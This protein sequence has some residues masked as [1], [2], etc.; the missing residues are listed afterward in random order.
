MLK[1][2]LVWATFILVA[3]SASMTLA[4]GNQDTGDVELYELRK[5]F[6]ETSLDGNRQ[7]VRYWQYGWSSFYG[8]SAAA[9]TALWIDAD[10]ND[11]RVNYA[12]GALKSAAGLTEMLL[13]PHPGR[14]G[15]TP[16]Q[17]MPQKTPAQRRQRLDSGESTLRDSAKRAESRYS[18]K[19]HIKVVGVNLVAGA[20]IAGFG[21]SGDA[22]TSTAIGIA[23][24]EA[25]IWTQPTRPEDDWRKYQQEFP[26]TGQVAEPAWQ[27]V[28]IFGGIALVGKF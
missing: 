26:L 9:Q 10:N 27:L 14:Y 19:S 24:G 6:I 13:R 22:L 1:R 2:F 12:I 21:D 20:L 28:P 17:G 15:A 18:W 7:H 3:S 11:D 16:M 8:L 5:D 4:A 25:N 23:V